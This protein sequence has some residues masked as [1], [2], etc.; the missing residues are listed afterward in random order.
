MA[1]KK[2]ADLLKKAGGELELAVALK[3]AKSSG[4]GRTLRLHEVAKKVYPN[5]K[6]YR[7]HATLIKELQKVIDGKNNRLI[8]QLPPRH[9]KS[10]LSSQL[11]PAAYL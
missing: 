2:Q 1:N 3:K 4:L 5:Y 6:F 10:L 9:G 8:I 7:L 11:F